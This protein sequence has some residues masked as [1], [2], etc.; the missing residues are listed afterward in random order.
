[1]WFKIYYPLEFFV[2]LF[3]NSLKEKFPSYFAEAM[4]KNI[5][6]VPADITKAGEG[7]TVHGEDNS[8][9]FG[10]GH[11]M[12]A[13]PA[14][15]NAIVKSQPFAS[16]EQFW[17]KT[18][19]IKKVSKSVV[20][21]LI[22]AHAFDC[23]GTQNEILEK[24][25]KE[26]RKDKKWERDVDYDDKRYEHEQFVEAYGL[27]WRAKLTDNHKTTLKSLGVKSLAKL[28][29]PKARYK[30]YVWGIVTEIINKTSKNG[31]NYYYVILTD[32]RFN[33]A[34]VRLPIYNKRCQKALVP[35]KDGKY[36]KV[37]I[38]DVVELNNIFVGE[39]ETSEYMDRIFVDM[40]D[41]CCIGNV[42]EKSEEQ[43]EKLA[44]YDALHDED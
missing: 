31:N 30:E 1:M 42:Y 21:A 26:I 5:K 43:K 13:G 33:V 14:A 20:L 16:F 19:Q 17:D 24:Y 38:E 18:S 4:A 40:F 29:Q 36:K 2:V 35:S 9:M 11:I 3:S 34:K 44:K 37:P 7:F 12:G 41:V 28:V 8:I 27:D 39:V 6:I 32:S 10:L 23:F 22:N 25:F 15:V